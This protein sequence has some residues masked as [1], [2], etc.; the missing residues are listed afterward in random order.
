[1]SMWQFNAAI[2]GYAKANS[3]DDDQAISKDEAK[4]LAELID[5][6]PVWH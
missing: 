2:G 6:P 4:A 5:E 3:A 1:M